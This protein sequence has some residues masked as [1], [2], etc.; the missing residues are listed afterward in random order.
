MQFNKKQIKQAR[1]FWLRNKIKILR[2]RDKVEKNSRD[3]Y[4]LKR[5]RWAAKILNWEKQK[6]VI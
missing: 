5:A 4:L 2:A 1:R 3:R 6:S